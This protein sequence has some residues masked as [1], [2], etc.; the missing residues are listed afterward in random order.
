M[1]T[2]K[3][4]QRRK[5]ASV[6]SI[7][8]Q[9]KAPDPNENRSLPH[10]AGNNADPIR[11]FFAYIR[12]PH[13]WVI[14]LIAFLSLGVLGAGL[15]Y[16]EDSAREEKAKRQQNPLGAKDEGLLAR[17]NP[18]MPAPTPT[19]TP[20]LSK[21]YIYAGSRLLA[22]ED[23]AASA[24]P[25]GDLAVWRPSNGNWYC[26]GGAGSQGFT[27]TWGTNGDVPVQGD[28]DGDGKTDLAI[29]RP[30]VGGAAALWWI[31]RS[32]DGSYYTVSLG[33]ANDKPAQADFDGDGKTDPA[34]FHSGTWNIYQSSSQTTVS[35]SFGLSSDIP[36]PADYDGDGKA[37]PAVWRDSSATFYFLRSSDGQWQSQT[38]GS[39]GYVPV[40]ADYDGDGKADYALKN[41]NSWIIKQSSDGQVN[42]T[43]WQQSWDLPVPN[44]YDGDGKVDIAVWRP[45]GKGTGNWYIRNSHDA[46][47]RVESWGASGDIPV[48]AFYR[49]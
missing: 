31:L 30:P 8:D 11:N 23:S 29:Y 36:A 13:W 39:T 16:L 10:P 6:N 9:T 40:P 43:T 41:G 14:A 28:Y 21:E 5:S 20:Q 47:I 32:S 12:N 44:D 19:P 42:T 27:V 49:R 7:T 26:L 15:K 22:V 38:L 34:V 2:N 1:P 3:K 45:S 25:P 35:T 18:F 48:P 37:D 17:L 4:S 24:I 46:S 33:L